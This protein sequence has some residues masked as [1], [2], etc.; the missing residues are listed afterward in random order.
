MQ[1]TKPNEIWGPGVRLQ[2]KACAAL[3]LE[4]ER[5][6]PKHLGTPVPRTCMNAFGTGYAKKSG[7]PLGFAQRRGRVQA[8]G[9][10]PPRET[11]TSRW[12]P[13]ALPVLPGDA[14]LGATSQ[15]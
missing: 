10:H 7:E 9:E 5:A 6:I 13:S 8:R 14:L 1:V 12:R 15:V 11:S 3:E 2:P 4:A